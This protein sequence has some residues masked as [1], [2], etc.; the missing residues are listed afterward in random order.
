MDSLYDR[1]AAFFRNLQ[2]ELCAALE[3][4]DE[5]VTFSADEWVREAGGSG[6]S[7]VLV[8][9]AVFEKAGVNW[10]SVQGELSEDAANELPGEG[11]EFRAT[12]ISLVLHPLS[13]M[14]PSAHASFRYFEQGE[15]RWFDG[16]ADLTPYYFHRDDAVHFHRI[17]KEACDRHAPIGDYARFKKWCDEY[18]Y[19]AHRDETRGV[20]GIFFEHLE[21]DDEI[22]EKTFA[23]VQDA[24]RAFL[25]AYAPIVERRRNEDYGDGER[26][27]QLLRRGRH[28]EFNLLY[29]RSTALGL[30]ANGLTESSLMSLPPLVRWD[31]E[32]P[33]ESGSREALMLSM[34]KPVDWLGIVR[35]NS[36]PSELY[37]LLVRRSAVIARHA[38]SDR[39]DRARPERGWRLLDECGMLS[40]VETGVGTGVESRQYYL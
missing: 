32:I 17:L 23:F 28:V 19:L 29:D 35:A 22:L 34:L 20:G 5:S 9:G 40:G 13:P 30:K 24:G 36:S 26:R 16:G 37:P 3:A 6:H 8:D 27:W 7:F 11:S 4:A 1:A 10:S 39:V 31:Y 21:G 2:S 33:V 14:V 25:H 18:F 15:S 12:G 38:P